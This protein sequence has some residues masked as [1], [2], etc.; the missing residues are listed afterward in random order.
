MVSSLP[1]SKRGYG[2]IICGIYVSATDGLIA[3]NPKYNGS[4]YILSP[5][6]AGDIYISFN[7]QVMV[8]PPH[9][10]LCMGGEPVPLSMPLLALSKALPQYTFITSNFLHHQDH[11]IVDVRLKET[12]EYICSLT[13]IESTWVPIIMGTVGG[14][15]HPRLLA[16]PNCIKDLDAF[17]I[18]TLTRARQTR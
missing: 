15:L 12:R 2:C 4:S 11:P 8:C 16:D 9:T 1:T 17:L 18:E 3:K 14:K 13:I 7:E 5:D 10:G 6:E